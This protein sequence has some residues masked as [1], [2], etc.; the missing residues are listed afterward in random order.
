MKFQKS[1]E[2][3]LCARATGL[4]TEIRPLYGLD[5]KLVSCSH[6]FMTR[7]QWCS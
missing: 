7:S 4:I 6:S 1:K 3:W 5:V 2:A